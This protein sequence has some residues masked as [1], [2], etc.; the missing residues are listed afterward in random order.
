MGK[1]FEESKKSYYLKQKAESVGQLNLPKDSTGGNSGYSYEVETVIQEAPSVYEI[2]KI[3]FSLRLG[4]IAYELAGSKCEACKKPCSIFDTLKADTAK[5]HTCN[6]AADFI[7]PN[8]QEAMS[9]LARQDLHDLVA[10]VLTQF[11]MDPNLAP[12]AADMALALVAKEQI[13]DI[14]HSADE[15]NRAIAFMDERICLERNSNVYNC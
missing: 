9:A 1:L 10:V 5:Q 14:Y 13:Y 15:L 7:T 6:L 11:N 4:E 8:Y 3:A 2:A 12:Q